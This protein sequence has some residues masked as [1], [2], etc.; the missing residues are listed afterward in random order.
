MPCASVEILTRSSESLVSTRSQTCIIISERGVTLQFNR[1]VRTVPYSCYNRVGTRYGSA[2][3][4][5]A[6]LTVL[7]HAK[8]GFVSCEHSI[9]LPTPSHIFCM[10]HLK[11]ELHK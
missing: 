10:L 8:H 2:L 6:I 7:Y 3:V 5:T 1:T 11:K 4:H 9:S